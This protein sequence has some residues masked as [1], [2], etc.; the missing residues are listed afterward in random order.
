MVGNIYVRG[1][2]EQ[3]HQL[4]ME[5]RQ[6]FSNGLKSVGLPANHGLCFDFFTAILQRMQVIVLALNPRLHEH[7]PML[8]WC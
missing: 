6:Q 7:D 5:N 4:M 8:I 1:I 3:P 2:N